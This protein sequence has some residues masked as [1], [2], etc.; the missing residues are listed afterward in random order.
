[1]RIE[2]LQGSLPIVE[3]PGL[4]SS[5][6]RFDEVA[7]LVQAGKHLEAA[8]LS[9]AILADGIY[10]IRLICYFLYGYWLEEGVVSLF[11]V[12]ICLNNIFIDNWEAVGPAAK[13]EKNFEK[14]LDWLFK[15]I[16]KTLQYEEKKNTQLWQQWQAGS[17]PEALGDILELGE[18]FRSGLN[19][20]LEDTA[21]AVIGVWSKIEEWLLV[22]Q[23]I[24]ARP[25][26]EPSPIEPEQIND[27]DS[28]VDV[29]PAE[30]KNTPPGLEIES[31]YHMELLL[32]KLSAFER[33]LEE[34][35]LSRAALLAV[36]INQTLSNFDPKLYFPKIFE[37]FVRLQAL[38]FEE[39][40]AYVE[41]QDDPQWQAMQAWLDVDVDGFM[42]Y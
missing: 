39:L 27:D 16:L 35:K 26:E 37:T 30:H 25:S 40:S 22:L 6:P 17:S 33:L 34:Q 14:S 9:E 15:Q 18:T 42:N 8:N 5:D 36:D 4:D 1:M 13:R 2:L 19:H 10:D 11:E 31:S 7:T 23:R 32:K 28:T 20:R 24:I 38:N 3:N 21:A 29:L 41:H 12:I